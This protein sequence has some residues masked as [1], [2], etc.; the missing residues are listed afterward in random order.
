MIRSIIGKRVEFIPLIIWCPFL[1][2]QQTL[3]LGV[4]FQGNN[5][6]P[7]QWKNAGG[8]MKRQPHVCNLW[9]EKCVSKC[10]SQLEMLLAAAPGH[11]PVGRLQK[12]AHTV[13]HPQGSLPLSEWA[14]EQ[15]QLPAPNIYITI[16]QMH[17]NAKTAHADAIPGS[18]AGEPRSSHPL[19]P[20][21]CYKA[22]LVWWIL[23]QLL[24]S[25][26][27]MWGDSF[28]HFRLLFG[29]SWK[30]WKRFALILT[31]KAFPVI[32]PMAHASCLYLP[33]C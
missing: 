10:W 23:K 16:E 7:G 18:R 21:V 28:F 3:Q 30:H 17:G 19:H 26:S 25:E 13:C 22:D 1:P 29:F 6:T 27:E 9:T 33:V 15:N 4:S 2:L 8:R 11:W 32:S 14:R 12:A 24:P 5:L 20:T 31:A